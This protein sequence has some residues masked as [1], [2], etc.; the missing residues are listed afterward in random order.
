MKIYI[1]SRAKLLI[2]FWDKIP[3]SSDSTLRIPT[4]QSVRAV[5]FLWWWHSGS[6]D[7]R[8]T[9][10]ESDSTKKILSVWKSLFL[11]G[12]VFNRQSMNKRKFKKNCTIHIQLDFYNNVMKTILGLFELLLNLKQFEENRFL[13]LECTAV[14]K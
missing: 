6:Y 11:V 14:I 10:C 13:P 7:M 5:W 1:L 3:R 12:L 9:S 2:T 8:E 4:L